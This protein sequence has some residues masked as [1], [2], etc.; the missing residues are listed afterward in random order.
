MRSFP[1]FALS[2]VISHMKECSDTSTSEIR[3]SGSLLY[4]LFLYGFLFRP[5]DECRAHTVGGSFGNLSGGVKSRQVNGTGPSS[6]FVVTAPGYHP[7]FLGISPNSHNTH[8]SKSPILYYSPMSPSI[9]NFV[10]VSRLINPTSSQKELTSIH[11]LNSIISFG[12]NP[13]PPHTNPIYSPNQFDLNTISLDPSTTNT[14]QN[15]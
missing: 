6:Q 8:N 15:P 11:I 13:N 14:N 1:N 9:P 10:V 3:N 4:R 2:V 12:S 7:S 5:S